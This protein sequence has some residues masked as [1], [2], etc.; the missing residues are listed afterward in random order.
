MLPFLQDAH[1]K[2]ACMYDEPLLACSPSEG[3]PTPSQNRTL[4]WMTHFEGVA[5]L[6]QSK[7]SRTKCTTPGPQLAGGFNSLEKQSVSVGSI[8]PSK[9]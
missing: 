5:S 4:I 8:F 2:L 3:Q 1:G 6:E 9:G 7:T